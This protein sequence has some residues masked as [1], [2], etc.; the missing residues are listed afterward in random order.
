LFLRESA[1]GKHNMTWLGISRLA[2]ASKAKPVM[3]LWHSQYCS[4]CCGCAGASKPSA[5]A[6][7]VPSK[8]G[9]QWHLVPVTG[10]AQG[11]QF[12][13]V[14]CVLARLRCCCYLLFCC[15]A[16]PAFETSRP[17]HACH[18]TTWSTVQTGCLCI[19]VSVLQA[20]AVVPNRAGCPDTPC[21]SM[22]WC[23]RR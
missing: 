7:L 6:R 1:E 3:V 12:A 21:I 17:A 19:Y 14:R 10:H 22:L 4:C 5:A 11:F 16:A 23:R 15:F 18:A 9:P 2:A 13:G 8:P 20:A